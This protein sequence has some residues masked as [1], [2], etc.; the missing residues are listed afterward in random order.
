MVVQQTT[1]LNKKPSRVSAVRALPWQ[2]PCCI[3]ATLGATH[4]GCAPL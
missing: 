3:W 2:T 1:V 4:A